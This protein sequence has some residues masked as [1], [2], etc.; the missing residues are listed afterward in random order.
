[1]TVYVGGT[2]PGINGQSGRVFLLDAATG[3]LVESFTPPTMNGQV[4]DLV[5]SGGRLYVSG[6]FTRVGGSEHRGLVALDAD[7]GATSDFL[8][9]QLTENHN[10][11]QGSNGARAGVGSSKV[12][13]DPAGTTLAVI[14][15]FRKADGLERD[16][17]ALIDLTG[18]QA[19]VR[20][21]WRTRRYEPACYSWAFDTYM[22][23]LAASPDGDYFVVSTT[24]GGNRGTLC[25]AAARWDI[26]ASGDDVQPAWVDE[27][28][29]DSLL[30]VTTSGTAVYAGGHQRWANNLNGRDFA[31]PGSVPRPGLT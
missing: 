24:G 22:R 16:Q 11:R 31:N 17:M 26:D 20:P 27:S 1:G 2:F 28:G 13:I 25:D 10:W 8:Q 30:G 5:L 18:P 15:N 9:V 14:G 21:D 23:D 4:R 12:A 7:S 19:E 3:D 6:L 29:G